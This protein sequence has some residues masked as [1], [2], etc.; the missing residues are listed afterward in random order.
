[1]SQRSHLVADNCF[2]CFFNIQD[3]RGINGER[4]AENAEYTEFGR[5]F[6]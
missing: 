2:L 4:T 5:V 1:M 3:L 6:A